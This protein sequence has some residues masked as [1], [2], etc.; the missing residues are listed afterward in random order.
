MLVLVSESHGSVWRFLVPISI[1]GPIHLLDGLVSVET[2]RE[3]NRNSQQDSHQKGKIMI[4]VMKTF[5][6]QVGSPVADEQREEVEGGGA[7]EGRERWH[8]DGVLIMCAIS[9]FWDTS[10]W[11][12]SWCLVHICDMTQPTDAYIWFE[13][14][15][16]PS[17]L[18]DDLFWSNTRNINHSVQVSYCNLVSNIIK[19]GK[20]TFFMRVMNVSSCWLPNTA[21]FDELDSIEPDTGHCETR[22]LLHYRR[23]GFQSFQNREVLLRPELLECNLPKCFVSQKQ[24]KIMFFYWK[25]RSVVLLCGETWKSQVGEHVSEIMKGGE[26][27]H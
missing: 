24:I 16:L 2:L 3:R 20:G 18:L 7:G 26:Q 4:M 5:G 19:G 1:S 17:K 22:P 14:L 23:T 6:S 12:A 13:Q 10:W 8:R 21:A 25:Q 9:R 11:K 15:E 27:R